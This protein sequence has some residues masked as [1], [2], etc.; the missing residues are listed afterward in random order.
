MPSKSLRSGQQYERKTKQKNAP[1]WFTKTWAIQDVLNVVVDRHPR[2]FNGPCIVRLPKPKFLKRWQWGMALFNT[3]PRP[4]RYNTTNRIMWYFMNGTCQEK[5]HRIHNNAAACLRPIFSRHDP[6]NSQ[7][8]TEM[9]TVPLP[10]TSGCA[11]YHVSSAAKVPW[12][13]R[14]L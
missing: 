9:A 4:P 6:G 10:E 2:L 1:V 8:T 3:G 11:K 12:L 5:T 13:T 7:L 14:N